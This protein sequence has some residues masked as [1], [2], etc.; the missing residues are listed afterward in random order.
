MAI[1]A[2]GPVGFVALAGLVLSTAGLARAQSAPGAQCESTLCDLY[3]GA[4]GNTPDAVPPTAVTAPGVPTGATPLTVPS[5]SGLLGW[6]GGNS[7]RNANLGGGAG[8]P[9]GAPRLAPPP[10]EDASSSNSYMHLGTGGI[11]GDHS[12]RCTGTLCDTFYG[13]SPTEPAMPAPTGQQA[14]MA[15]A[16]GREP[17]V[18]RRHIPHESETRPSCN[19]PAAD[20]WHCMR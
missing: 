5:G 2:K 16:T 14:A 15:P 9:G 17:V 18:A 3:Y 10:S 12:Q 20:P 6:F 11:L 4:R 7:S 1:S 8:T 13:S 19:S